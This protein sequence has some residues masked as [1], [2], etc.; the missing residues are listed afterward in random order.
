MTFAKIKDRAFDA[1]KSGREHLTNAFERKHVIVG[2]GTLIS[3]CAD[4]V[5]ELFVRQGFEV[6]KFTFLERNSEGCLLVIG[7][8]EMR[9]NVQAL[10]GHSLAVWVRFRMNGSDAEV[11]IG[12]GKW[13]DKAFSGVVAWMFFAP[14]M[15][16]PCFGAW[17]QCALIKYAD[18]VVSSWLKRNRNRIGAID[19]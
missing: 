12:S 9:W 15:V 18:E 8:P 11:E 7:K 10:F 3:D 16:I 6:R 2:G 13:I 5:S 14:L 4:S 19:V 17:K 1:Y